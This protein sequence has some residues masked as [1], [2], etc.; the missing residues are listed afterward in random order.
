MQALAENEILG[1]LANARMPAMPQILLQLMEVCRNDNAGIP[2]LAA[3]ISRDA[4]MTSRI[5]T[6]AASPAFRRTRAAPNLEQALLTIG[7]NMVKT[8][9]ISEAVFQVFGSFSLRRKVDLRGFWIHSLSAAIIAREIARHIDYPRQEEAYLAGLLHDVGRLALL[10]AEPEQYAAHF[11]APDDAALCAREQEL[12]QLTHADAGGWIAHQWRL[13]SFI[14]DSIRYHHDPEKRLQ[15]THPL[16]RAVKLANQLTPGLRSDTAAVTAAAQLCGLKQEDVD[17]ICAAA[18]EEIRKIADYLGIDIATVGDT[19]TPPVLTPEDE[20]RE[21]L[22]SHFN[23]LV[24]GASLDGCFDDEGSATVG[25]IARAAC[26]LFGFDAALVLLHNPGANAL[27]GNVAEATDA[28]D[29]EAMAFSLPLA[30]E[31]TLAT[32]L[33]TRKVTYLLPGDTAPTVFEEQLQR[34]LDGTHMVAVALTEGNASHGILVASVDESLLASLQAREAMLSTFGS[35]AGKALAQAAARSIGRNAQGG[36]AIDQ[37]TVFRSLAHE[38]NTPLSIIRNYLSVLDRKMSKK[39]SIGNEISII[40]EE[41]DRV[42]ALIN[43]VA[44]PSVPAAPQQADI[45]ATIRGVV[46]LLR[47]SEVAPPGVNIS[48]QSLDA[49]LEVPAD[50]G[51]LKQIFLNLVKNAVEALPGGGQI[52]IVHKGFTRQDSNLYLAIAVRDNGPGLPD[53]VLARLYTPVKSTKGGNHRGLGLSIVHGLV[54]KLGGRM[55]CHS[56]KDGTT[57]ELLFPTST[58]PGS[59][60]P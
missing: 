59:S 7:L 47:D 33:T 30:E 39:E 2:A 51:T 27:Q 9:L 35:Q 19:W 37:G 40:H 41:I 4:G 24:F 42:T 13:D 45:S 5:L 53:D 15:H 14:A 50:N 18:G 31:G 17:K 56:G 49:P 43:N 12:L 52:D 6:V 38:V 58:A 60:P 21:K 28:A 16:I 22:A 23:D 57:F 20:A 11:Y 10:S 26:V 8:L 3:L 34:F 44:A 54:G 46:A 25:S 32:A 55:Y 36:A 29:N 1:R 48:L